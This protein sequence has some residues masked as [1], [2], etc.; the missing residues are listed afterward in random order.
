MNVIDILP[1][2]VYHFHYDKAQEF[3]DYADQVDNHIHEYY[4]NV[5]SD[6]PKTQIVEQDKIPPKLLEFI[7][8]SFEE[9][10]FDMRIKYTEYD[11]KLIWVNSHSSRTISEHKFHIHQ[12]S[13]FSGVYYF[14][15]V[16][17]DRITFR[18]ADVDF[19]RYND[20]FRIDESQFNVVE[21]DISVNDGDLL[22]FRSDYQH[23]VKEFST[24]GLEKRISMAFNIDLKGIGSKKRLTCR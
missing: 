1:K 19:T 17:N 5:G 22:F 20:I 4:Q 6:Y 7:F 16:T 23:G 3:T 21:H 14:R 13:L 11:L 12:N 9:M 10:M 18:D 8:E 2:Q 15:T 24:I